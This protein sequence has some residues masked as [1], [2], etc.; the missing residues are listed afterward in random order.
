MARPLLFKIL[1]SIIA[2]SL[3]AL[4]YHGAI[5]DIG[6][7]TTEQGFKRALIS[8]G[9]A[10]GLNGVISVAQGTEVAFEPVGIGL[11]FTPGEILDPVND[12][13]E[14][15]SW[16]M[17]V[18]GTSSGIQ[19]VLLEMTS[20]TVFTAIV[21]VATVFALILMWFN[22]SDVYLNRVIFYRLSLALIILRFCVPIAALSSEYIYNKFLE[23][24]YNASLDQLK[25][26]SSRLNELNEETQKQKL[27][28]QG[29]ISFLEGMRNY[30]SEATNFKIQARID[31]FKTAADNIS[32]Y[33]ISLI[34]VFVIQTILLPLLFLWLTI[35]LLKWVL[36]CSFNN[37][38]PDAN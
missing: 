27:S 36:M 6:M 14:R 29:E 22:K 26:T 16:I 23:P 28:D 33:T 12:L 7:E 34:V 9:I 8:Y 2:F 20:V 21:T 30:L 18:S 19:R 24:E 3:L 31:A 17:L 13:I 25:N 10:R 32:E 4:A 5:D 38:T 11:T 1:V 35:K 37:I 15:F